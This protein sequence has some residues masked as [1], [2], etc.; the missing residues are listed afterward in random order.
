MDDLD[1]DR[2]PV[3]D[4]DRYVGVVAA[5]DVVKLDEILERSGAGAGGG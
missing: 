4:D 3:L 5:A 2:L 1:L